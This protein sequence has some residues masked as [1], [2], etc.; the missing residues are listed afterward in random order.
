MSRL[1]MWLLAVLVPV[2]ALSLLAGRVWINPLH[3]PFPAAMAILWQLRLPR[4]CLALA[5]GA[6]L[7]GAGAA[8]QAYLRNPLADPGLF[9]I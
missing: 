4:A 8:M 2:L 9:G 6:G 7:G 5:V 1:S 3:P